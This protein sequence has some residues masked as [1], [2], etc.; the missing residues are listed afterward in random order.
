MKNRAIS[1]M[2]VLAISGAGFF[3]AH[4]FAN[5]QIPQPPSRGPG[6][7]ESP[8]NSPAEIGTPVRIPDSA[9]WLDPKNTGE[10]KPG[11]WTVVDV[12]GLW[13]PYCA[14][15][16]AGLVDLERKHRQAGVG[17]ITLAGTDEPGMLEYTQ[18]WGIGWPVGHSVTRSDLAALGAFNE[19]ARIPGYE[20]KPTL[21]LVGPDG[22]LAWTDNHSRFRH[23]TPSATLKALDEAISKGTGKP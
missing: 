12:V 19:S 1:V 11:Q 21:L 14:A 20:A 23:E 9:H 13:C 17:F 5:R 15:S 22:R 6:Q 4:H 2:V 16:A 3:V 8:T 18:K 7:V 10:L